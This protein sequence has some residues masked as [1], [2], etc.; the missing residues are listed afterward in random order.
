MTPTF[1]FEE[2][3]HTYRDSGGIEIPSVTQILEGVGLS[4]YSS[5]PEHRLEFKRDIGDAVHYAARYLDLDKL[6]W[7]TVQPKPA[8]YLMGWINFLEETGFV[9]EAVEV[10]G[11]HT[12][13]GM[14]YAYTYD[15]V[16]RFPGIP[17]R[18]LVE[19]KC[20]YAEEPSWRP[21][22]AG[23]ELP[24]KNGKDEHLVK[25][26]VQLKPDGTYRI[27]PNMDGYRD[28]N[29]LKVFLWGLALTQWKIINGISWR[30]NG[31]GNG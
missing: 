4:D 25:I 27:W 15:R 3:T 30:K 16:G 11:I 6:D 20:A 19:I 5:V 14:R 7:S 31:N 29:D 26:A 23:Y 2:A 28:P 1:S 21:Q 13:A 22:L 18:Y 12:Y 8:G 9:I 10:S 24:V 17:Y